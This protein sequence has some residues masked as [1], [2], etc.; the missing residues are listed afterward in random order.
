MV[1]VVKSTVLNAP[2]EAVWDH[3]KYADLA[4]Y[5]PDDLDDLRVELDAGCPG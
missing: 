4:N 3:T 2:V 5:I 1:R